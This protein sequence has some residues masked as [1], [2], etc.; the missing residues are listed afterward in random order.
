MNAMQIEGT[1]LKACICIFL[2]VL[3]YTAKDMQCASLLPYPV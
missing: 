1:Q 2:F 3:K